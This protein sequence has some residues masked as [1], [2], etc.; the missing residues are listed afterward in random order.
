MAAG[1][2]TGMRDD[3]QGGTM[4]GSAVLFHTHIDPFLVVSS[5]SAGG[6]GFLIKPYF[7]ICTAG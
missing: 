1:A 2:G 3:G 7:N 5:L 6:G 4:R